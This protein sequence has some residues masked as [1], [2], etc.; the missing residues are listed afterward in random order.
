MPR[1]M[2]VE[3][4]EIILDNLSQILNISGLDVIEAEDGLEA[5][6]KLLDYKSRPQQAPQMIIS[7][8]TMPRMDGFTL[9]EHVRQDSV[10]RDIPFVLLTAHSDVS[11]LKRAFELGATDY[12]IK[13]F[14]IDELIA[15]VSLHLKPLKT[16]VDFSAPRSQGVLS[17]SGFF[18]E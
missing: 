8:L 6:A 3:D 18:L 16:G 7:D 13:P 17:D 2:I 12:L 14:E 9:L 15:M 11:D 5:Y 10:Y 1:V 4:Q